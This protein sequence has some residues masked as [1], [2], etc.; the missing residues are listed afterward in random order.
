MIVK[1]I[2]QSIREGIANC[3]QKVSKISHFYKT[4]SIEIKG[5][6]ESYIHGLL[7]W[8]F[9]DISTVYSGKHDNSVFNSTMSV[10]HFHFHCA[11]LRFVDINTREERFQHDWAAAVRALFETFVNNWGSHDSQFLSFTGWD[12]V[13]H[14]S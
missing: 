14:K 3:K 2:S 6:V 7:N 13:S 8:T 5:F 10:K 12:A 11:N 9:H 4:N 1:H